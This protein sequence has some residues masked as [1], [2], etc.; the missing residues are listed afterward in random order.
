M[1]NPV[2]RISKEARQRYNATYYD[3]H[4]DEILQYQKKLYD[5]KLCKVVTCECGRTVTVGNMK[6]HLRTPIHHKYL[7]KKKKKEEKRLRIE[8]QR[9]ENDKCISIPQ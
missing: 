9:E 3:K 8:K 2:P 7:E 1:E 4:H 5:E 6:K